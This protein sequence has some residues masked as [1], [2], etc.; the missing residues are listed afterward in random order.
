IAVRARKGGDPPSSWTPVLDALEGEVG[1]E[2]AERLLVVGERAESLG[3]RHGALELYRCAFEIAAAVHAPALAVDAARFQG[4]VHRRFAR[5]DESVRSYRVAQ[6]VSSAAN[7]HDRAARVLVGLA[8]A[9]HENGK[10]TGAGTGYM[11]ASDASPR[12]GDRDVLATVHHGLLALEHAAGNIEVAL[13]QGWIAVA[14]YEDARGR[15]RCLAGL[16]GALVDFGDRAAAEDAWTVVAEQ[17]DESYYRIYAHDSLAYLA[18]LRRD[19][20]EFE[21]HVRLCDALEW[22]SGPVSARGEILYYRGLSYAALGMADAAARWLGR[23]VS[24]A[25]EH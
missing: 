7:L 4:R 20:A 11:E 24:F 6:E 12:S 13:E 16:A 19:L 10:L 1:P 23:A 21:R 18:A 2:L 8:S 25:E 9:R 14:T 22:E 15:L 17:S 5:W 3:H